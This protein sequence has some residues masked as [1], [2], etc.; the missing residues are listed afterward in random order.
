MKP[1]ERGDRT[2]AVVLAALARAGYT[3][4]IPF[5]VAR[6][7]MAI[8]AMDGTGIKTVQCKTARL[9]RGCVIFRTHSLD[10]Q[11]GVR[12][13]YKGEVDYFGV[14]C[15]AR[16]DATYLV[17][18]EEVPEIYGWLRVDPAKNGQ[19]AKIKWASQYEVKGL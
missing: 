13:G 15:P 16:P 8:D 18:V 6:Y 5:G 11:T 14:W 12:R 2:E 19:A 4:L 3:V 17:P 9:D 1:S 10:R 7:D